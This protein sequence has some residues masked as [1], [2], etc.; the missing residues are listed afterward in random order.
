[1]KSSDLLLLMPEIILAVGAMVALMVGVF[2]KGV[3]SAR[4]T[5][6]VSLAVMVLALVALWSSGQNQLVLDPFNGLLRLDGF[7][8]YV[9]SLCL[10]GGAMA[11]L[12]GWQWLERESL[13]RFEIPV[14]VVIAILGMWLMADAHNLLSLYV[15]LELQSLCLFVLAAIN[16]DHRESSE[17][18]LKYFLLG[19]LSSGL[20]L[21]GAS[22]IYG[23][24]GSLGFT[25]IAAAVKGMG[26]ASLS[27]GLLMGMVLVISGLAF[28]ISA[29]PFHMWTPDVYQGSPTPVTGFFAVAPKV[30]AMAPLVRLLVGPFAE[31]Q[32]SWQQIIILMAVASMVLGAFAAITQNSIKRLLAYSSIA[33]MGYGLIGLA[34]GTVDGIAGLLLYL[35]IYAVM[36][37]GA[38]GVILL[39]RRG[40]TSLDRL[41][42]LAGLSKHHPK[43]AFAL[44]VFM[45]SMAGIPPLAG[46]FG[47]YFIFLSA[48][49]AG[50]YVL[51]VVGV[52]SSVVAAYY[53]L[54]IVKIIYFDEARSSFEAPGRIQSWVVGVAV[55]LIV[56][57]FLLPN[58]LINQTR[59]AAAPLFK[60]EAE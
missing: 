55:V 32:E 38:F 47:K 35:S 49:D 11:L 2:T 19:A 4:L 54:R 13:G 50:F 25:E 46:F 39:L 31:M 20:L 34:V 7:G 37:V 42:D 57:Y 22:L 3:L 10:I 28:K 51:A 33:N 5:L 30:A 53:Y 45:F 60:T 18:G 24:T 26:A 9:K 14:L 40:G 56:G 36:T 21:Y 58:G 1:M 41:S 15:G 12:M 44:A 6:T 16:R 52:L 29:V 17:A 23:A 59:A 27:L 43:T 8:L 48:I